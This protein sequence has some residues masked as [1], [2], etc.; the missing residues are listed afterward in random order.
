[1]ENN[2]KID[3]IIEMGGYID[4]V[5]PLLMF[6]AEKG[7]EPTNGTEYAKD[8]VF[9]IAVL[10]E[11]SQLQVLTRKINGIYGIIINAKKPLG[12]VETEGMCVEPIQ[13][14]EINGNHFVTTWADLEMALKE[15]KGKKE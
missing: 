5:N 2:L 6:V 4:L 3:N 15:K 14:D 9:A 1:M 10:A 12:L 13:T 8:C 7:F 11:K